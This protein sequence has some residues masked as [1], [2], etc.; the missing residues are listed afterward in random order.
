MLFVS[1]TT[2]NENNSN[3][4]MTINFFKNEDWA[5]KYCTI[6]IIINANKANNKTRPVV[7]PNWILL[8]ISASPNIN[9]VTKMLAVPTKALLITLGSNPD[10]LNAKI[11][12]KEAEKRENNINFNPNL[13]ECVR[14]HGQELCH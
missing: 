6:L 8:I 1:Y 10:F 7:G 14:W 3:E 11:T 5:I 12:P 9:I 4:A 13:C 2:N